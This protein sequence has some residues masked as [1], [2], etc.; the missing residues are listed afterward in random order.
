MK[1]S[2]FETIRDKRAW[3]EPS[4]PAAAAREAAIGSKGWYTRGYLPH[5][6][7]PGVMQMVTFRLADAM[8]AALRQEWEHLLAIEDEREQRTRLEEYLDKGRGECVLRGNRAAAVEE[9]LLRFNHARYRLAAWVVMPNHVHA[10]VELGDLPLGKLLQAWKG[11]SANAVNRL[12]GCGGQLWQTDY[13]DRYMRDEAHFR[14]AW[15]YIESN[16]VKAGLVRSPEDWPWSSANPKWQ[17]SVTDR[18]HARLLG[19]AARSADISVGE[20][21]DE[22]R[23]HADKNVRAPIASGSANERAQKSLSA[24]RAISLKHADRNVGATQA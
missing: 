11:A 7:Q 10:L 16:P 22:E 14:K 6:D 8:P 20:S 23:Q 21:R 15:R 2:V 3:A 19:S 4:P 9:V 18:Y 17:W 24:S 12:L 13:W 1:R 5:Y